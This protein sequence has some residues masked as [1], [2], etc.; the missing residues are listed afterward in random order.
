MQVYRQNVPHRLSLI[1]AGITSVFENILKIDSTKKL[2]RELS[3][4]AQG[5]AAWCTNIGNE[6]GQVLSSILTAAEG[7]GI[8]PLIDGIM[9]R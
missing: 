1:K 4:K 8:A 9:R 5:S 2:V 7:S 3:A 6:Y